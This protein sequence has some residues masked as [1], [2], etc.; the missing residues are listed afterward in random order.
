MALVG[1]E[2]FCDAVKCSSSSSPTTSN[3]SSTLESRQRFP[4]CPGCLFK[5]RVAVPRT[6]SP[7][8]K[9]SSR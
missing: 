6:T 4:N 9:Y 1:F 7:L 8:N 5:K 2:V 3:S